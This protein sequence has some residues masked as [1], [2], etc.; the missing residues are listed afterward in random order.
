MKKNGLILLLL[1][2]SFFGEI[3][4]GP[5]R[6]IH[7]VHSGALRV[8]PGVSEGS[9]TDSILRYWLSARVVNDNHPVTN[10]LYFWTSLPDLDSSLQQDRLLR[11]TSTDF[12]F[13]EQYRDNLLYYSK[14]NEPMTNH[15][16]GSERNYIRAAWP[17]YWSNMEYDYDTTKPRRQQLVQVV[18]MDSSLIVSFFP[19]K[20][21]KERW[22]IHDLRG[23]LVT[24]EDALKRK[25][26]IA[27]VFVSG[28]Q[29]V[30][31]NGP[32]RS[33]FREHYRTFFLCNESMIKSWHHAV[34]GVQMKVMQDFDYLVLLNAW[35]GSPEHCAEQG[36]K[37]KT[38]YAAWTKLSSQ[39]SVSELFFATMRR[40]GYLHDKA[41]QATTMPMLDDLRARLRAQASPCERFPGKK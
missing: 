4:A 40:A 31:F 6:S 32:R 17:S 35:F 16:L 29:K 15:L 38:C 25:R 26:H 33:V 21:K 18:L 10:T 22:Q 8:I 34:P 36:T 7:E 19:D 30:V 11:S 2:T 5:W 14:D 13:E 12:V 23:N 41:S 20:K 3:H 9:S 37:G 1:F 27:A 24:M 39:Q 28:E